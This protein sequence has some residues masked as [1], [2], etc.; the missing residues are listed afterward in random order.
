MQEKN[1]DHCDRK[2]AQAQCL[3]VDQDRGKEDRRH[4]EGALGGNAR[5][6]YHE[7]AGAGEQRDAGRRLL[8]RTRRASGSIRASRAARP[9]RRARRQSPYAGRKSPGGG[10]GPRPRS[11]SAS[12]GAMKLRS[13]DIRAAAKPPALAP[14]ASLTCVASCRRQ[15]PTI[16]SARANSPG[17]RPSAPPRHRPWT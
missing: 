1:S 12:S 4:D 10:P 11:A 5:P 6:G 13:P 3:P 8:N 16:R 15:A 7:I 14:A 2:A 9:D 17:G